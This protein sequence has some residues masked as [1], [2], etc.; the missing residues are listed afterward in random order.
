MEGVIDSVIGEQPRKKFAL[1]C[2]LSMIWEVMFELLIFP[3]TRFQPVSVWYSACT[4]YKLPLLSVLRAG[5][6]MDWKREETSVVSCPHCVMCFFSQS[7][8]LSH[9][10]IA[11]SKV[12]C[13]HCGEVFN[14]RQ[15]LSYH[16]DKRHRQ[17]EELRCHICGKAFTRMWSKKKHIEVVHQG[18]FAMN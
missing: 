10:V 1:F 12:P 11:H 4:C 2:L 7:L 6:E 18:L 14:S 8:L 16:L 15:S 13:L 9:L 17:R 5:I 3:A